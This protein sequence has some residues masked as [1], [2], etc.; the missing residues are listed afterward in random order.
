[1][2]TMSCKKISIIHGMNL[3]FACCY[4]TVFWVPFIKYLTGSF[5]QYIGV[6]CL[7]GWIITSLMIESYI[8]TIRYSYKVC[9]FIYIFVMVCSAFCGIGDARSVIMGYSAFWFFAIMISFYIDKKL[10]RELRIIITIMLVIIIITNFTTIFANIRYSNISKMKGYALLDDQI[11][12]RLNVGKYDYITALSISY[13]AFML[14]H[15][16]RKNIFSIMLLVSS[17]LAVVLSGYTIASIM[18]LIGILFGYISISGKKY[19][20]YIC[21]IV[22]SIFLCIFSS[23]FLNILKDINNHL[24]ERIQEV[25]GFLF[26]ENTGGS[27]NSGD[28]QGRFFEY[29]KSLSVFENYIF[30][31]LGPIYS[32]ITNAGRIGMHSQIID[33]M[34]RYGIISVVLFFAFLRSYYRYMCHVSIESIKVVKVVLF[35]FSITALLNPLFTSAA[36]GFMFLFM[37][38]GILNIVVCLKGE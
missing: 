37:I 32:D 26:T 38:P 9:A 6:S 15:V 25:I 27:Y 2:E 10:N 21:V 24:Y 16:K 4:M 20:P 13:P 7:A 33:D 14:F 23:F 28:L 12:N 11:Y 31:G 22:I 30:W 36:V 1:M 17:V 3:F 34:A 5:Y 19:F 18:L 35:L 8:I 29:F